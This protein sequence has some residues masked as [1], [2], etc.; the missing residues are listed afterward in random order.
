MWSLGILLVFLMSADAYVR[1]SIAGLIAQPILIK[2]AS[3]IGSTSLLIAICSVVG[4]FTFVTPILL[5]I[6]TKKYVTEVHYDAATSTYT[7]TTFNFFLVRKKISFKP[8]DVEV[9]DI[10][11][12]FTTMF[13]KGKPLF[14]EARHFDDPLHYAKIMGYDKPIDFKLGETDNEDI[15]K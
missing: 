1:S 15:K 14:I 2:E 8:D 4:F 3:T 10:P 6:I 9:P 11:G 13:A 5:H 12:M 7:A